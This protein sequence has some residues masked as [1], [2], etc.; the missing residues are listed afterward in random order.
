MR[1]A[2]GI[3]CSIIYGQDARSPISPETQHAL[4][5]AYAPP[6]VTAERVEGQLQGI[7]EHLRLVSPQAVVVQRRLLT[8]PR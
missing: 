1:D 5:V 7:E 6:G 4:Y 3:S 2:E 8:A